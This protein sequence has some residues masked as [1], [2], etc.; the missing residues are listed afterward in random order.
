M[1]KVLAEA[2]REGRLTADPSF[3]ELLQQASNDV[4]EAYQIAQAMLSQ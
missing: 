1:L 4:V 2:F 3:D